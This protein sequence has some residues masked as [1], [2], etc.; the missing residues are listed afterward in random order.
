MIYFKEDFCCFT[1]Y[2]LCV[3]HQPVK[4]ASCV[5]VLKEPISNGRSDLLLSQI[6]DWAQL[7]GLGSIIDQSVWFE[8][9]IP[10]SRLPFQYN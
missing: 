10:V 4:S 8:G 2:I 7:A 1:L 5:F 3:I 6:F 9:G